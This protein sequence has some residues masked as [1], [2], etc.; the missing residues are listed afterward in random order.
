MNMCPIFY[1]TSYKELLLFKFSQAYGG[2]II[3]YVILHY[4]TLYSVTLFIIIL[5]VKFWVSICVQ[6]HLTTKWKVWYSNPDFFTLEFFCSI[7]CYPKQPNDS[8]VM[9]IRARKI[10]HSLTWPVRPNSGTKA[11]LVFWLSLPSPS[12]HMQPMG[13]CLYVGATK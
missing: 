10:R 5:R 8:W 12:F 3:Y 9:W 13:I 7:R 6:H 4:V 11:T 2:D 1:F